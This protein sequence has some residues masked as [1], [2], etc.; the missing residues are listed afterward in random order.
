MIVLD[1]SVAAKWFL[2]EAN[3][4]EAQAL[5]VSRSRLIAPLLIRMEV[6]AAIIQRLRQGTFKE[7]IA[8][9]ACRDWENMLGDGMIHLIADEELFSQAVEIAFHSRHALQDCFY[10]AAAA[11]TGAEL[12][13]ADETMFDRGRKVVPQMRFLGGGHAH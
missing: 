12:V 1:A 8:R 4:A 5:L 2:P 3:Q 13:T 9:Q 11:S 10:L 7:S 6:N